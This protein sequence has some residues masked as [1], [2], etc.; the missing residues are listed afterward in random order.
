MKEKAGDRSGEAEQQAS[1]GNRV[2]LCTTPQAASLGWRV[3]F[4]SMASL[5]LC[6]P[7]VGGSDP[8]CLSFM[9]L[10]CL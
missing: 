5:F 1:I 3:G 6:L 7:M 2:W 4:G 10:L 9:R 8:A